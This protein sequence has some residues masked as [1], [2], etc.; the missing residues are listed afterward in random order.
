MSTL[1]DLTGQKFERLTVL[2]KLPP[3]KSKKGRGAY[4]HCKCDC[5][6]EADVLGANLRKG[7]TKSCGCYNKEKVG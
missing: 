4:W 1:I 7:A 3:D 2:Y 6:N 5:G